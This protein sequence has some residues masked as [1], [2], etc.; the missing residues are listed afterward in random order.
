[1]RKRIGLAR[2]LILKPEIMLYDEPTTGLDPATSKEISNL[3][4]KMQE[5][6][7]VTSVIVTHDMECARLTADRIVVLKDGVFA[8]EGIYDELQKS[9]DEFVRGFFE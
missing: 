4:L 8:A 1:M 2:T 3:I 6:F 7:K 9:D 5:K